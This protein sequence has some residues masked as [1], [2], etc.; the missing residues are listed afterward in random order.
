MIGTS[1][2]SPERLHLVDEL[3]AVFTFVIH[4]VAPV[5]L[6]YS[7][8]GLTDSLAEMTGFGERLVD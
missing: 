7:T 1:D 8:M 4:A 6:Y 5:N 2:S 3:G